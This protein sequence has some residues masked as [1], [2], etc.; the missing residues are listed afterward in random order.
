MPRQHPYR[1]EYGTTVV[2]HLALVERLLTAYWPEMTDEER[3][4]VA[5]RLLRA[6]EHLADLAAES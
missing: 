5:E 6:A 1:P 3:Q 4:A 2:R